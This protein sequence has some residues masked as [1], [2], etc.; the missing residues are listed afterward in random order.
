VVVS[1][2]NREL[3]E[4]DLNDSVAEVYASA[5]AVREAD[6]ACRVLRDEHAAKRDRAR[7]LQMAL[8][9]L[10]GQDK[11]RADADE[12]IDE[13]LSALEEV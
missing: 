8:F 2:S 6:A 12:A 4:S 1:T 11:S 3:I 13:A 10:D 5:E 9:A 7:N